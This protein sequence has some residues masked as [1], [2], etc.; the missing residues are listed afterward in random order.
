MRHISVYLPR[1]LICICIAQGLTCK[2]ETDNSQVGNVN[3][4]QGQIGTL[5]KATLSINNEIFTVELALT[6]EALAQSVHEELPDRFRCSF[7]R[8]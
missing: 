3:G 7:H 1:L 5:P 2:K 8:S 4:N 6:H